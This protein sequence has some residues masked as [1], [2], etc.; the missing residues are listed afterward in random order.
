VTAPSAETGRGHRGRRLAGRLSLA[1]L[2]CCLAAGCVVRTA[3]YA[4]RMPDSPDHREAVRL[5]NCV[6]CHEPDRIRLHEPKDDCASCHRIC[7][8]C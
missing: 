3:L 4:P 6:D 8:G 2:L 5:K 1:A 7:T